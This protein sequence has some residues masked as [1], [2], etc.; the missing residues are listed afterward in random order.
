INADVKSGYNT[1]RVTQAVLERLNHME[2]PRGYS[3]VPGGELETRTESFG[4]LQSAL[5]IA[6]LGIVAIL[7]LEFGHFQSTLI[8]LTVVPFGIA[9]GILMLGL[10][11]NTISFT[12]TIGF[13]A[14]IRIETQNSSLLVRL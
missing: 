11:G 12:A 13:I 10:T 8:V 14:L 3:Y 4:G 5:V 7:G 2:W 6:L 9:G 1:D